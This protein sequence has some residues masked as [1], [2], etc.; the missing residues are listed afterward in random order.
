M[1]DSVLVSGA[2]SNVLIINNTN[3]S[4]EGVYKCVASSKGGM[5]ESDL[6]TVT[7]YGK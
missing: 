4:D 3:K 2:T 7:V 5:V 6:A 1:K